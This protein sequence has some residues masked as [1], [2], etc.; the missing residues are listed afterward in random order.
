[1]AQPKMSILRANTLELH[2]WFKDDTHTMDAIIQ[3]KCEFEFL[4]VIKEVAANF[5]IEISI[6]T[7]PLADGG[8]RRWFKVITKSENK[9][10]V[11]TTALI[12]ALVTGIFVTPL[13]TSISKVTENI[14]NKFFEDEELKLLEKEKLKEE[15]ENIKLDTELKRQKLSQNNVIVKKR[16]NFYEAL[17]KYP[18]VHQFSIN[19]AD[20]NKHQLSEDK[21]I[22]RENFQEYVL[23]SDSLEPKIVDHAIIEIISPVLKKGNYK[24]KG[25]YDGVVRSFNMKSSEFKALVQSG[26]IEFKNGS[27]ID[28]LLEIERKLNNEGIEEFTNF[29]IKRVNH[30][31]EDA[32]PVETLE[33]KVHRQKQ[34]AD[35]QQLKLAFSK[36]NDGQAEK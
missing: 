10:P 8:L 23:V 19:L 12:T 3:N 5:D 27:A 6:E 31:F 35:K 30:Y 29:N 28:C 1:M 9:S 11:I 24:W 25:I 34:E 17:N 4:G 22:P 33:G 2:Y 21:F 20:E 7:E 18:K 14:V 16:S 32:K 26:K 36:D 13:T 15:I